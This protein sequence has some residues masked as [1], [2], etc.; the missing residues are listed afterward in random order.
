[1]LY[2]P[3]E[4]AVQQRGGQLIDRG[5]LGLE[6]GADLLDD[7]KLLSQISGNTSLLR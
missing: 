3:I 2:L 4:G 6:G 7:A 5:E 1:M